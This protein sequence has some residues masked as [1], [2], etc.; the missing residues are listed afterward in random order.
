MP[1]DSP[2]QR[3]RVVIDCDPGVDDALAMLAALANPGWQLDFITTVAGN[4]A[5][6]AVT[7]NAL[8]IV[9]LTGR[10]DVPVFAGAAGPLARSPE[11]SGTDNALPGI[12]VDVSPAQL[13]DQAVP[14]LRRWL[15]APSALPKRLIA[16]GP[17]TNIAALASQE[18]EALRSLDALYIMGGSVARRGGRFSPVAET[19]FYLDPDAAAIVLRSGAPIRL[20]D[21]DATSSTT[22]DAELRE[23]VEVSVPQPFRRP[24]GAWF[25]A[26][27]DAQVVRQRRP[28]W[29]VHDLCAVAGAAGIEPGRWET[30]H[31]S[32]ELGA[33]RGALVSSPTSLD[34]PAAIYVARD[35]DTRAILRFLTSNMRQLPTAERSAQR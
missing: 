23:H 10:D 32:V 24:V 18:A 12:H 13:A 28:G 14:E 2:Q 21:Y 3:F 15:L 6:E 29:A 8:G 33:E 19:N 7:A 34:D 30:L 16:I 17:L 22:V 9:A 20:F 25:D 1:R 26:L 5:I 35:L 11:R 4:G 31:M 27:H